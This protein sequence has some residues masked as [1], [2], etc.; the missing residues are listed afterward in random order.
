MREAV[1][2]WLEL[3]KRGGIWEYV[4]ARRKAIRHETL[5]EEI[6]RRNLKKPLKIPF[7]KSSIKVAL[8][9]QRKN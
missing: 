2:F 3:G 8:K 7:S 9:F 1:S 5:Y 6:A 4:G